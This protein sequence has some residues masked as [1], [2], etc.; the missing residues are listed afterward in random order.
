MGAFLASGLGLAGKQAEILAAGLDEILTG[1]TKVLWLQ[2]MSCTGCSISFLNCDEPG[3]LEVLTQLI[4]LVYH[5]NVSAAQGTDAVQVV[6]TA[7]KE[8]G[9]VLVV[10][11]AVSAA[12]PESCTVGGKPFTAILAPALRNAKAIVAAGTCASFGGIPAAEGNPTQATGLKAFMEKEGIPVQGR[13]VN[14]AGCPMHPQALLSTI[15]YIA[16]KGYPAVNPVLLTPDMVYKHSVHDECP[17]FHYWE[18]RQFAEKFGEEGCLFKLGC[19]G[20]LSHGDCPRRQWNGGVN[21]C[22]RAGAPCTACTSESFARRRDFPFYRLGEQHHDV[23]YSE[24]DRK[25]AVS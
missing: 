5:Q 25:G 16:A 9:Y 8:G 10:E 21:W 1:R 19:L 18:K 11:G 15:A 12:M 7:V 6:E 24:Q 20:P 17:R 23:N 4:S 13:L 14:C 22:V 2:G 3:P